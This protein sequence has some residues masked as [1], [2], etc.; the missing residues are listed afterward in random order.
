MPRWV[1]SS[2]N[3]ISRTVPAVSEMTIR[4]TLPKVRVPTTL[5]PALSWKTLKRKT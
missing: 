1:I 4:K 3:H 5:V 2:P